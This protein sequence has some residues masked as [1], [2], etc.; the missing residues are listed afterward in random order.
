MWQTGSSTGFAAWHRCAI[1]FWDGGI[2]PS[3]GPQSDFSVV[4]LIYLW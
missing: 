2:R 3:F 4:G 1:P